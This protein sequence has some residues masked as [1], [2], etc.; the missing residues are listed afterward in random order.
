MEEAAAIIEDKERGRYVPL[1][2]PEDINEYEMREAFCETLENVGR[3]DM[4]L[5]AIQGQGAFR[6]FKDAI[7]RL[8]IERQWYTFKNQAYAEITHE[9]CKENGI[10]YEE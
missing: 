9:W 2:D 5:I 7:H 1:P 3:R 8:G 10:D 6:R 4:L